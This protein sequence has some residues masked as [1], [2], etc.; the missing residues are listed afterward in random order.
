MSRSS[1]FNKSFIYSACGGLTSLISVVSAV[2][3]RRWMPPETFGLWSMT[4]VIVGTV[5]KFDLG[6]GNAIMRNVPLAQGQNNEKQIHGLQA[7]SIVLSV[8][9]GVLAGL[10][11]LIY[12]YA[13]RPGGDFSGV[14]IWVGAAVILAFTPVTA[15][16]RECMM[17]S[18]YFA[19][20]GFL[21]MLTSLIVQSIRLV[22]GFLF[23]AVGLIAGGMIAACFSAGLGTLFVFLLD[24]KGRIKEVS[25]ERIQ[26][27]LSVGIGLR[28]SDYPANFFMTIDSLA[29]GVLFGSKA[30]A[31]YMTATMVV[32]LIGAPVGFLSSSV[33]N[34]W[35]VRLGKEP[36]DQSIARGSYT[37]LKYQTL[38]IWPLFTL[39]AYLST[40]VVISLFIP[41]YYET[42]PVLKILMVS[43]VFTPWSYS[44][45]DLWIVRKD[46][47]HLFC[48]GCAG[49]VSFLIT[50]GVLLYLNELNGILVVAIAY[51]IS[52]L[53]YKVTLLA[54]IGKEM[55]GN[56]Q[57]IYAGAMLFFSAI[58]IWLVLQLATLPP[59]MDVRDDYVLI[60]ERLFYCM[61]MLSPLTSF[62]I[63]KSWP[64]LMLLYKNY[65]S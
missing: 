26:V 28:I 31:L 36:N 19:H 1:I 62:G 44:I 35:R 46:F 21:N 12:Y 55:W 58:L 15:V 16:L 27:L 6:I 18:G 61:L 37:I 42:L 22:C 57:T 48:T 50:L 43:W 3:L 13:V 38:L 33:R 5:M 11:V 17:A 56:H 59:G 63:Y 65:R 45:R 25:L 52:C 64:L 29:V 51:L 14:L 8:A 53:I 24:V 7:S 34:I 20:V 40:Q 30:L 32:K 10:G 49:P 41:K 2:L 60:I 39:I 9:H 23:A 54:T 47:R 4:T